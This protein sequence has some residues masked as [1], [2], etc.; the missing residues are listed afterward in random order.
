MNIELLSKADLL[1]I[2]EELQHLRKML[3]EI[4]ENEAK[5][6]ADDLSSQPGFLSLS[7]AAKL[8]GVSPNTL[9]RIIASGA[10]RAAPLVPGGQP[11]ISKTEFLRFMES[12]GRVSIKTKGKVPPAFQDI[13]NQK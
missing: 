7:Q 5:K 10:L 3:Q 4:K 12:H 11:R 2:L 8:A 1:P 13:L 6:P 9:S